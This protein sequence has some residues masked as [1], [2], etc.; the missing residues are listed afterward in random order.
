[1]VVP[2]A[3]PPQYTV[4]ASCGTV[5]LPTFG[6]SANTRPVIRTRTRPSRLTFALPLPLMTQSMPPGATPNRVGPPCAVVLL[7]NSAEF[8]T[9]LSW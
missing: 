1:L 7:P 9:A 5:F 3:M 8:R 6:P 4:A 2:A